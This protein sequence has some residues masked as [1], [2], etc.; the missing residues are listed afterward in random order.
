MQ[1][2][3]R[4]RAAENKAQQWLQQQGLTPVTKNFNAKGGEIDLIMMDGSTLVFVEV[5]HR[6]QGTDT[7]LASVDWRKQRRIIKA[8]QQYLQRQSTWP[9]C[10]FDVIAMATD[11]SPIWIKAAFDV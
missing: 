10:R 3:L 9:A 4:G 7:A 5:R 8:A 1:H 11:E 6:T 2:W